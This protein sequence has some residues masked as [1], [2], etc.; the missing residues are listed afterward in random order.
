LAA[1]H[2]ALIYRF[3]IIVMP[4]FIITALLLAGCAAAIPPAASTITLEPSKTALQTELADP[5]LAVPA[6]TP[7]A[8][9]AEN[10]DPELIPSLVETPAGRARFPSGWGYY[11]NPDFVQGLAVHDNTI[12]VAS[13]GGVTSW[14]LE[15]EEYILYTTRDGLVEIQS[16]DIV[17]CSMPKPRI[18]VAHETSSLSVYDLEQKKWIWL[19]ITFDDGSTMQSVRTLFCDAKTKRLIAGSPQGVAVLDFE[20]GK[21][22]RIGEKEGLKSNTIHA[23][24]AVG[25]SI[26]V[27]AGDKSVYLLIG[28]TVFPYSAS[29]GLPR[30]PV[31]DITVDAEG[32][33]WMAYP[34]SLVRYTEKRWNEFGAQSPTGIPFNAVAYVEAGLDD[35]IWIASADQ[36]VCPFSRKRLFCPTIYP[37]LSGYQITSLIVDAN[38]VAYAGTNGGGVLVLRPDEVRTLAVGA[39]QLMDNDVRDITE[40][41]DGRLWIATSKGVN[42]FDPSQPSEAWETILPARNKLIFPRVSRLQPAADGM[43]FFY[44]NENQA[45]FFDG[46]N[47]MQMDQYKGLTSPVLDSAVDQRGYLWLAAQQGLHIWDGATMRSYG[48]STGLP[49]SSYRAVL[50]IDSEMWVGTDRGLLHYHRFQWESLL[51][52]I[53][54]NTIVAGRPSGLL[55][56]TSQGLIRYIDGQSFLWIL[57]IGN[58]II[59]NPPITSVAWDQAGHLWAGTDG[60]G[61]FHF[62]GKQWERFDTSRG[63]PTNN[64]RKI[65]V[66]RSG[67]IWFLATT[68]KGGGAI[69]RYTP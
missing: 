66:D 34:T 14:D 68:G 58:E 20:S 1:F 67:T 54:I 17:Y 44:E 43:W 50:E 41:A 62:D 37:G 4:V 12:W 40:S 30:G 26:W 65:L 53:Q 22:Q 9:P 19:P 56:G 6:A 25:Q 21:W 33:V 42:I 7:T 38:N 49:G 45:S 5:T 48:P 64:I 23:I 10:G 8:V 60:Y 59:T 55:L 63:M 51:P 18:I 35:T 39:G 2:R 24:H 13:Y 15:T 31:Y 47:W 52:G 61:V 3:A 57:N 69:V 32:S 27:A 36:G 11:S 28:K 16:N 46:D 29:N